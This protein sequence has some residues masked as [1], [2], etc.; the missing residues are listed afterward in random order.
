MLRGAPHD[1]VADAVARS[2]SLIRLVFADLS[3]E[4]VVQELYR[5]ILGRDADVTGLATRQLALVQGQTTLD[6]A[7]ELA[8]TGEAMLIPRHRRSRVAE[9]LRLWSDI[10][11]AVDLGLVTWSVA[12]TGHVPGRARCEAFVEA[13]YEVGLERRPTEPERVADVDRLV[14]GVPRDQLVEMF[15][16]RPEVVE[17]MTGRTPGR[18]Q[19]RLVRRRLA[20]R[21]APLVTAAEER[22]VGEVVQVLARYDVVIERA[23]AVGEGGS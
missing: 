20:A 14:D 11:V 7:K 12:P 10:L 13:L 21:L 22:R 17:R 5:E 8:A 3:P 6:A 18:V 16:G 9:Q 19:R 15:A 1:E 23:R 2:V 4:A